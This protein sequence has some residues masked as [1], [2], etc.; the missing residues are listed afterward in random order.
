MISEEAYDGEV[1]PCTTSIEANGATTIEKVDLIFVGGFPFAVL[2][3]VDVPGGMAP[4]V[5][6][7]VDPRFLQGPL[8]GPTGLRYTHQMTIRLPADLI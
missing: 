6:A 4:S 5:A 2:Q 8:P 3:W 7:K 1:F